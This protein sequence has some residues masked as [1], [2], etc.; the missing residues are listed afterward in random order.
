MSAQ[1]E[2]PKYRCHKEVGALKIAEVDGYT[3]LFEDDSY[4]PMYVGPQFVDKHSPRAGGY[5]VAYADGYR[6][7]SPAKAFEEGYTLIK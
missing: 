3:L 6:S 7:Y 4:A 2:M 1:K 5:L